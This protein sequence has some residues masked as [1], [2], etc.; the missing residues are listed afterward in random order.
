MADDGRLG[1]VASDPLRSISQGVRVEIHQGDP[2]L[3]WRKLAPVKK[4]AGAYAHIQMIRRDVL[5]I[6]LDQTWSRTPPDKAVREGAETAQQVACPV[7]HR[8]GMGFSIN[9]DSAAGIFTGQ[10]AANL[11]GSFDNEADANIFKATFGSSFGSL[12][13][14]N[15]AQTGLSEDFVFDDLT[16]VGSVASGGDLGNV[17]VDY[18]PEPTSVLLLCVGLAIGLVHFRRVNR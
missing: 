4:V 15:V 5:V 1:L 14:G 13:F 8:L 12:R 18:V 3:A 9:T 10:P 16:V 17:N 6:V 2:R 11:A 7:I